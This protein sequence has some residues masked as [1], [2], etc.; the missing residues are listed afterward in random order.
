MGLI[1]GSKNGIKVFSM[2]PVLLKEIKIVC[3]FVTNDICNIAN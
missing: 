2:I 3:N 1:T